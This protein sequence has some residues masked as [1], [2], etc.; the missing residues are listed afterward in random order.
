MKTFSLNNPVIRAEFLKLKS[1][2]RRNVHL[3][4]EPIIIRTVTDSRS[5]STA[6]SVSKTMGDKPTKTWRDTITE[7]TM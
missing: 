1:Q 4:Q 5:Y 3:Y 6:P 7:I 2:V